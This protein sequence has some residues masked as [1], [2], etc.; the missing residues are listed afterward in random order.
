M[1]YHVNEPISINT[2][3][4]KEPISDTDG[5]LIRMSHNMLANSQQGRSPEDFTSRGG[6]VLMLAVGEIQP[7]CELSLS[8]SLLPLSQQPAHFSLSGV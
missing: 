5:T 8:F 4:T 7:S 1:V 6:N 3:N 2:V